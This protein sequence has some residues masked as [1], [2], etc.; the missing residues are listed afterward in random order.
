[1]RDGLQQIDPRGHATDL[2]SDRAV[3]EIREQATAEQPFF[4]YLAYNAPHTPIQPPE[5]WVERVRQ[6]EPEATDERVRY[7]ALVEHL[8]ADVSLAKWVQT[9]LPLDLVS[10][11]LCRQ[12]LQ[13]CLDAAQGKLDL[14]SLVAERDNA[15]RDLSCFAA[16]VVAAPSKVKG[17]MSTNEESVKSLILGIRTDALQHRRKEIEKIRQASQAGTGPRLVPAEDR[18]LELEHCQLGYD[19]A[20]MKNWDTAVPVM[21]L[22]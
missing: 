8:A 4:L 17:D 20:R 14:M 19:L 9:Y 10:D 6:R 18:K 1:M 15:A 5:E 16:R 12:M 13:V 7:V 22:L 11:A 3:E 21:E 2:F